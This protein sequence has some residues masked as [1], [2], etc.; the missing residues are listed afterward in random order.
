MTF[1]LFERRGGVGA[2]FVGSCR[3]VES[4]VPV[5]FRFREWNCGGSGLAAGVGAASMAGDEVAADDAAASLADERVTLE[6]MRTYSRS[7]SRQR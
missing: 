1:C 2:V 4:V 3:G 6:D 7:A 5:A